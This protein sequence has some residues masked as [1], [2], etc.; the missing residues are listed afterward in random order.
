MRAY[1]NEET[2][3]VEVFNS[4]PDEVMTVEEF[5][6]RQ[7]SKARQAKIDELLAQ[8]RELGLHV[9]VEE[10]PEE[11]APAAEPEAAQEPEPVP[12]QADET[13]AVKAKRW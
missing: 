2:K 1:F 3:M 11:A 8:L 10:V 12:A 5:E 9:T 7:A 4:E 6:A 13:V